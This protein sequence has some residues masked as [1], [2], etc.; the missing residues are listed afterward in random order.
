MNCSRNW[1]VGAMVAV[2]I[3]AGGMRSA[4]AADY[5]N[6][7]LLV[8]A[9]RLNEMLKR[10]DVRL[11]DVRP[12]ADYDAG[13][14]PGAVS[15]PA[16]AVND[17]DAHVEG[18]RLSDDRLA[19]LFGSRGIGR[20]TQVVL[21]DD[22]GGFHSARLFWM[23]EYLGHRKAAILNGGIQKWTAEGHRLSL[24][25]PKVRPA[26]FTPTPNERRIATADWLL[27]RRS[28]PD[29]VLVDVRPPAVRAKGYIPWARSIPWAQ[30]LN[31]DR[32]MKSADALLAHF[33]SHG[34]TPDR[35]IATHCQDGK[36]SGHSYFTLRLLG[37][38]R[39]RSYDRSWAE[40]GADP[41]LPKVM[42]AG[43]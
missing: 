41:D 28:D 5:A 17:P 38:A 22:N 21:Y 32:T 42:P 18:A 10:D 24:E 43:G 7:H 2:A 9:A 3:C 33:A 39:I 11:V 20:N 4:Q 23:L 8:S 13:H 30:N 35:N 26:P 40:W 36:A 31:P 1:L 6:P 27:E 34:V 19:A 25:Q 29:V 12:K 37:F 14:L 15:I 16:D